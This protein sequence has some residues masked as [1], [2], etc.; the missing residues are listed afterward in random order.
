MSS[1]NYN[2]FR[3]TSN[4]SFTPKKIY[5][6]E[7]E[8]VYKLNFFNIDN[9]SSSRIKEKK[10]MSE[11]KPIQSIQTSELFNSIEKVKKFLPNIVN[12]INI[13][14]NK[15]TESKLFNRLAH[16]EYEKSYKNE[17]KKITEQRE[18]IKK[19][20][21]EKSEKV[22][23][24]EK[25]LSDIE[26]S[27]KVFT[28]LKNI[29]LNNKNDV[30]K[31]IIKRFSVKEI[32]TSKLNLLSNKKNNNDNL[33]NNKNNINKCNSTINQRN[34]FKMET[35]NNNNEEIKK[36]D[37]IISSEGSKIKDGEFISKM[38]REFSI[39]KLQKNEI[40]LEIKKLEKEKEDLKKKSEK[41]IEH[42][43]L[44]YLDILKE[45]TDTRNEGLVWI[46]KEI[47]NLGKIV[48]ISYFP[49]YLSESEILYIFKQAKLK[50]LLED[51]EKQI[52]EIRKELIELNLLKKVNKEN[53]E[54]NKINDINIK[55]YKYKDKEKNNNISKIKL[56]KELSDYSIKYKPKILDSNIKI[57]SNYNSKMNFFNEYSKFNST[58]RTSFT[59]NNN[60]KNCNIGDI[61]LKTNNYDNNN[62]PLNHLNNK[63]LNDK[64]MNIFININ[65]NIFSPKLNKLSRNNYKFINKNLGIGKKLLGK[66]S[67]KLDLSNISLIPSKLTLTEVKE[68]IN[69]K[70]SRIN[71]S[72]YGKIKEYFFL[73][74][75]ILNVKKLLNEMKK[76]KIKKLFDV[77]FKNGYNINLTAE[78][79]KILSS[80]I[81][82]DN[83]LQ[84]L[85]KQKKEIKLY[86]KSINKSE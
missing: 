11:L 15:K 17:L 41:I 40:Y 48:L 34:S 18:K 38:K 39:I 77:N 86:L 35:D 9:L 73:N 53:K 57:I 33:N 5:T 66:E 51:Y 2:L 3:S 83:I 37:I 85:N 74:K 63:N 46:V 59:N 78:K 16:Q 68:F 28:N 70:N 44:Y 43:Y 12:L 7:K 20:I 84:E 65:N 47:L 81:G 14:E 58:S 79:E 76:K 6:R 22:Q 32:K 45:G 82:E 1:S 26:L 71:E 52:Q 69:S 36:D 64:K 21:F 27:L 30:K 61:S 80:L 60:D 24:L 72:N 67:H 42:L 10:L 54:N 8:E 50:I 29:P 13:T 56:K 62:S 75:K 25:K 55:S 31:K 4:N 23:K 49:K 19:I